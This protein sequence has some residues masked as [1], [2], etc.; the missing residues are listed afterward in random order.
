M[1]FIGI[2]QRAQQAQ[3]A[4]KAPQQ[5]ERRTLALDRTLVARTGGGNARV[6]RAGGF[7]QFG[8][9]APYK[10]DRRGESMLVR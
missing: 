3:A 9:S 10:D 8:E 2:A 1:R 7:S 5:R 4:R 6:Q